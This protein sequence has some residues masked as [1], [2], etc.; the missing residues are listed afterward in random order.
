MDKDLPSLEATLWRYSQTRK[1]NSDVQVD[2]A[3][4]FLR[5]DRSL[6]ADPVSPLD[7]MILDNFASIMPIIT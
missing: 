4:V 6:L 1:C 7:S 3:P 5:K 2:W